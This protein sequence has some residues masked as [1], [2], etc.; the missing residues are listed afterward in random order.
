MA[1][2]VVADGTAVVLEVPASSVVPG[3]AN[4]NGVS[5]SAFLRR[6]ITNQLKHTYL[7]RLQTLQLR[8][9]EGYGVNMR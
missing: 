2:V 1:G 9:I 6:V 8:L 5:P 7:V 3:N 4:T